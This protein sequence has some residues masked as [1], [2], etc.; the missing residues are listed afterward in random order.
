MSLILQLSR[1]ICPRS[2]TACDR[3][4]ALS[5]LSEAAK[6]A[7]NLQRVKSVVHHVKLNQQRY[8]STSSSNGP[9]I[10]RRQS[11]YKPPK[12]YSSSELLSLDPHF[13]AAARVDASNSSERMQIKEVLKLVDPK[14][15]RENIALA[16]GLFAFA[17]GVMVYSMY[18]VGRGDVPTE[19]GTMV[20]LEEAAAEARLIRVNEESDEEDMKE[21]IAGDLQGGELVMANDDESR[22]DEEG[23]Q[24][25]LWKH[26]FSY[27]IEK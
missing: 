6:A 26:V 4:I 11:G 23:K 1:Q 10:G 19:D 7:N 5:T 17:A 22:E 14:V 20:A 24:P 15:R 16:I 12:A 13:A 8:Q 2:R 9:S 21:M 3:V 18:A 25:P 27:W